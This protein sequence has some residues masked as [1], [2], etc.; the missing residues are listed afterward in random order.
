[1]Q[2]KIT[3]FPKGQMRKILYVMLVGM[4][5]ALAACGKKAG[6]VADTASTTEVYTSVQELLLKG[7]YQKAEARIDPTFAQ[8]TTTQ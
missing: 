3:V 5:L 7:E 8:G 6:D 1:M 2:E 4:L